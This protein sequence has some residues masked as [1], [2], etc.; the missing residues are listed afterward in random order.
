MKVSKPRGA[1]QHAEPGRTRG[2]GRFARWRGRA[3][4]IVGSGG[5]A[6]ASLVAGT[7]SAADAQALAQGQPA[8]PTASA[9]SVAGAAGPLAA[10]GHTRTVTLINGDRVAVT[11]TRSGAL[12]GAAVRVSGGGINRALVR[13]SLAGKDYAVPAD[14]LPYLNRGLSPG[15]FE[16]N[17]LVR[18]RSGGRL[19]VQVSYRG[20]VPSLPGVTIT[21]SGRGTARGYLTAASAAAFGTA[22]ARQFVA[23]HAR[24]SYGTDGMFAA[25]VSVGLPGEVPAPVPDYRMH[26]LTVTGTDLAGQ[27]DTGDFVDVFNVDSLLKFSDPEESGNVFYQGTAKFSVPA[28]H[29]MAVGFFIGLS[30]TTVTAVRIVVLP[31]FSVTGTTA[32]AVSEQAAA[33]EVQMVTPQPAVTQDLAVDLHR[34][35]ADGEVLDG[36]IDAGNLPLW[37]NQTTQPVTVG[38]LQTVTTGYLT[39]PGGASPPYQYNLAF[40]GPSGLIGPQ[41]FAV[42]AQNTAAVRA[43]FYQ[44]RASLGAWSPLGVF[45]FQLNGLLFSS[46][47]PFSLP[48]SGTQYFSAGPALFWLDEYWQSFATL[49]GGQFDTTRTFAPGEVTTQAWNAFPLHPTPNVNLLG[50]GNPFPALPT[51]SRAGNTLSLDVAPFGDNTPGHTGSGFSAGIFGS[52]GTVTGRYQLDQNGK[53]IAAGNAAAAAQGGPYLFLQARLSGRPATIRFTLTAARTGRLYRLSTASQTVWTWRSARRPGARLPAGWICA[54]LTQS[55]SV[56]PMLT[57][58][59]RVRGLAVDGSA[60]PGRQLIQVTVGHLQLARAARITGVTAAA[61]ADGGRTW[62]PAR[63][64]PAGGGRFRVMFPAPPGVRVSLRVHAA[65]AAGGQVTETI[66]DGYRTKAAAAAGSGQGPA[67]AGPGTAAVPGSAS[68]PPPSSPPLLP[69]PV[70]GDGPMRAACPPPRPGHAQCFALYAR[71]VRV[72]AAI[73]AGVAGAPSVPVGWGARAIES[74]YKLPVSRNPHQTVAVVDAYRTPALAANLAVYRQRYGLPACTKASG[75]LRIVNQQG[76]ASPLPA[77]GVPTG[78]DV[79]TMLDVSMVSAACPR[80]RILVVEASSDSVADLAAAEDTA[81]RLGAQV[82][83]NSYGI[84]ENGL[85]QPYAAAYDHPGHT[86]VV[87]SGD[88]GFTAAN[89]PANLATVTAAGGTELARAHNARGWSEQVWLTPF[90]GASGSGCSAYVAKPSWQRDRHCPG[91]TVADVSALAWNVPIYEKVQGGWLTVGGTSASAPLIAGVYG[92]AGNAATA[93]PGYPY[94]RPGSLFDITVGNNDFF[95]LANGASCG[96]DYL[97]TAKKSYDAPTG[98]GTPDGTGAF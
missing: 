22:L 29:Y 50:T 83:S 94:A 70:P 59:Y 91:R 53:Q 14:A 66:T 71:Q 16:L 36:S 58:S 69:A 35:T 97:C 5:L 49:S 61:S 73:A 33:N 20:A 52:L 17:S 47:Y 72:N 62:R 31:Q 4:A 67:G 43:P 42:T 9:A 1:G 64:R 48:W 41:Q 13:L 2:P 65:D 56:Q 38:A 32:V 89:F 63:V 81:A 46:I 26:T 15:L 6:A 92:L 60:P 11:V 86:I 90:A 51:A 39:S 93:S 55:C 84:R 40:A 23:D 98:L 3:V 87:S 96:Y 77:S 28:G 79:E 80:C 37:M 12:A 95:N 21:S 8:A 10:A 18:L 85:V 19:P 68:T 82:I 76:K 34:V 7:G 54:D 44:D 75:C 25:G 88:A 27:P 30:A 57:L 24:G 78:W 74:A 45:G